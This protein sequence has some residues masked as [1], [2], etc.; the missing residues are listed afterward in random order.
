M[1]ILSTLLCLF[2]WTS[3]AAQEK[4]KTSFGSDFAKAWKRHKI[5]T[6]RL[7][8]AMPEKSYDYKP[9]DNARSFKEM[10][11]HLAGANYMFSS[12]ASS[13]DSPV[14][15]SMFNADGKTKE[16]IVKMLTESFDYALNAVLNVGEETLNKTS[17]WG[18]PIESSTTRSYREIFH[19][20][21]EHAAHHRGAMTV[22]LRL[23]GITPPGFID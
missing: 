20:M 10:A 21:R 17:P 11:M 16:Q 15:R 5:Y 23:N 22:Y 14:D 9:E 2:I 3:I 8:E 4:S 12:I 1:R 19:V 13:Q 7:V 6:L 18:N